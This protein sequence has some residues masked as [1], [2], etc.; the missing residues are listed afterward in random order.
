MCGISGIYRFDGKKVLEDKIETQI[1]C[2]RHRGPDGEGIYVKDHLGLGHVRL[3]IIELS[4]SGAQPM[5]HGND[6]FI[7]SYNG[8]TYNYEDLRATLAPNTQFAGGSDTEVILNG[9]VQRGIDFVKQMEGMFAFAFYD[10]KHDALLL[11]KR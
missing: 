11:K 8:E 3:S 7:L 9:L 1:A 6:D 4:E 5:T 2:I 10:S